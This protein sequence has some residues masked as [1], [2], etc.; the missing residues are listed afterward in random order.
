MQSIEQSKAQIRGA[1]ERFWFRYRL[2]QRDANP[3]ALR[4]HRSALRYLILDYRRVCA[5]PGA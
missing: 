2:A 1:I 3:D 5:L 4:F